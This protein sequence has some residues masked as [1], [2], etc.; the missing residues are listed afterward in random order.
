M[1]LDF[2]NY[3]DH[4]G[5]GCGEKWSPSDCSSI[6][7]LTNR[8]KLFYIETIGESDLKPTK[9]SEITYMELDTM[10]AVIE[11]HGIVVISSVLIL[12][13]NIKKKQL[14]HYL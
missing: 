10:R 1:V 9:S 8:E 5:G 12:P 6:P 11:V 7:Y 14:Y 4:P 2:G 13:G 3:R